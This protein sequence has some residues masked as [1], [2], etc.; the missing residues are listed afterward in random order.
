MVARQKP[1]E[2]LHIPGWIAQGRAAFKGHLT[3][4]VTLD[5][6]HLPYNRPLLEYLREQF[7]EGREIYLATA[8]DRELAERIANYLGIFA[9][10][11]ASDGTTG[12]VNLAG[13]NKL[14]AMRARFGENFCY[15]GNARPDVELLSA[16]VS[17][18]VANPDGALR[19]GM[20]RTGTVAAAR[21]EDRG[22]V[23]A[24]LAEGDPAAPVGEECAA[25]CAA[26]AGAPV[27]SADVWRG[28]YGV[29]QFW[30]V[31]FGYVHH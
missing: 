21:F 16:C 30:D 29:L 3:R 9:G 4:L 15:I 10:V 6:E 5:V 2:L 24:E 19:A 31:R 17:P 8:A 27:A 14:A 25:V 12:G 18:M 7:G 23:A 13:G 11:L 20:K 22:P 1:K 26:A 28:D